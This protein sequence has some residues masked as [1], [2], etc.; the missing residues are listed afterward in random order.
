MK[1]SINMRIISLFLIALLAL[2]LS[3]CVKPDDS[4]EP[5]KGQNQNDNQQGD[6]Q[7]ADQTNQPDDNQQTQAKRVE[8]T[9]TKVTK[10]ADGIVNFTVRTTDEQEYIMNVHSDFAGKP[11]LGDTASVAIE[12]EISE[13][14]PY[15]ATAASIDV[16]KEFAGVPQN[17]Q[18]YHISDISSTEFE[19]SFDSSGWVFEQ[20]SDYEECRAYL[21][22]NQL[23]DK[24]NS[25]IGDMDITNL[26]D[27]FFKENKLYLFVS[28]QNTSDEPTA[29]EVSLM[30]NV[31]YLRVTETS[32][33]AT[34]NNTSYKAFLIPMSKNNEV[35]DGILL[36]ERILANNLGENID[37]EN[38]PFD[39]TQQGDDQQTPDQQDG[40]N[41][42]E[43]DAGSGEQGGG[44][45]P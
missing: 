2:S 27:E 23:G 25:T 22:K 5:N 16:T 45:N 7:N 33:E 43:Q 30:D 10:N 24:L 36:Y 32:T 35:S 28:S 38:G 13:T 37:Q 40:Q 8:G 9:I 3:G 15:Q 42:D 1:K 44:E 20:F 26:T 34:L 31:L 17:I 19:N 39:D 4:G 18:V 14:A 29:N 41:S 21:D 6:D 11:N 12:G